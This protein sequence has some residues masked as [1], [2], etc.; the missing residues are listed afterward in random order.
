MTR[1]LSLL[2]L[3]LLS[4]PALAGDGDGLLGKVDSALSKFS[5]Q[6]IRFEV[7]NQ[8][9]G[10][11][12]TT[13]LLFETRVKG[14]KSYTAFLAP[15]DL[16]GTRIL[17]LSPSEIW[18]YLPE[19]GKV[20]R[21]ASSTT[22]QGFMGTVLTQQD[23][24]APAYAAYY[25][26]AIQ[27]AEGATTVLQLTAKDASK[28][29]YKTLRMTVDTTKNVPTT[30]EYLSDA[31]DVVRTETRSG[32]ACND[33]GYC[34]FGEMKMV[35]HSRSDAWT[36]LKPVESKTDTGIDDGIFTVRTLQVGL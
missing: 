19:F 4:A 2:A 11:K 17:S 33:N 35:D 36:V 8:K 32:Y 10:A 3:T 25:D 16:K 7:I 21:V 14:G 20:R 29:A 13:T 30:I 28:V 18:V 26:A 22:E 24:A 5:D 15:G 1:I 6:Y 23:M 34:L 27:S 31:G 9:P 12:S